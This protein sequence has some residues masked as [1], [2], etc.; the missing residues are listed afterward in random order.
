[1]TLEVALLQMVS[2]DR[3]PD[4]LAVACRTCNRSK[5]AMT[6]EEWLAAVNG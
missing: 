1:M 6:V 3:V 2:G 5:R 4:N